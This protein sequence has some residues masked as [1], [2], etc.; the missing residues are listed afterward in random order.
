MVGAAVA[1][2][3]SGLAVIPALGVVPREMSRPPAWVGIV[4]LALI[5]LS[6]FFGLPTYLV[7]LLTAVPLAYRLSHAG[8]RT[9]TA[10]RL[11][12]TA[13]CA[14]LVVPLLLFLAPGL[15]LRT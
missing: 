10:W 5:L 7:L 12:A 14:L 1:M 2:V 11:V 6:L 15:L 13:L 8:P 4:G 9:L 3:A